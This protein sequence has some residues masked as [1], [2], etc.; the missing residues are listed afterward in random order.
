MKLSKQQRRLK[1]RTE[2]YDAH[3]KN[4]QM[5]RNPSNGNGQGHDMHRPG[6]NKK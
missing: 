6:S 2:A 5:G 1:A 3:G 4:P